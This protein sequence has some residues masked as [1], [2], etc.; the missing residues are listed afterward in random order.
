MKKRI[1]AL[2]LAA[3]MVL[4][5]ALLSGCSSADSG[6]MELLKLTDVLVDGKFILEEKSYN[7]PWR[8]SRNQ[9]LIDV[10]KSLEQQSAV[11]LED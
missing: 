6:V 9:R 10:K 7:V 2:L 4:P 8:G 3:V 1:F 11:T 5:T